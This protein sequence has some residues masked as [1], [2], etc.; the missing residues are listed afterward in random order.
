MITKEDILVAIKLDGT[1]KDEDDWWTSYTDEQGNV[2]DI[3]VY[4]ADLGGQTETPA[5]AHVTVY[6]CELGSDGYYQA[7]YEDPI[8]GFTLGEEL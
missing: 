8:F 5:K 3:N 1:Y 6:P 4:I 2:Y 7:L